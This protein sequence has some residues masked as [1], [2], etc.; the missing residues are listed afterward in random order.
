MVKRLGPGPKSGVSISIWWTVSVLCYPLM[1]INL[2][3][4]VEIKRNL[5]AISIE[6]ARVTRNKNIIF[7]VCPIDD[8]DDEEASSSF[9][10]GDS[11]D[12][13]HSHQLWSTLIADPKW[14]DHRIS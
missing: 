7:A 10:I 1:P 12:I 8:D 14:D 2:S 6:N 4:G 5:N 11:G 3:I 13:C 9:P